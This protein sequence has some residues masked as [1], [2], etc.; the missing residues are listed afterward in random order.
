M[1]FWFEVTVADGNIDIRR[2]KV[3]ELKA[4]KIADPRV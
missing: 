1:Y 4:I 3:S 2:L